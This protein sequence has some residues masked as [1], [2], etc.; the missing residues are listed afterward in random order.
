MKS[1]QRKTTISWGR[2]K[3]R[4]EAQ[5]R[6]S[7]GEK[8]AEKQKRREQDVRVAWNMDLGNRL[9]GFEY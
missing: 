4:G 6:W 1:A 9:P 7:E 5:P 8:T 3:C 2:W